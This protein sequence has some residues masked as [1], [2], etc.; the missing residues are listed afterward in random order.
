MVILRLILA[1]LAQASLYRTAVSHQTRAHASNHSTNLHAASPASAPL[2]QAAQR[3]QDPSP[4][5]K[6]AFPYT[7]PC[8][9]Y[10]IAL[11]LLGIIGNVFPAGTADTFPTIFGIPTILSLSPEIAFY[12]LKVCTR[13]KV[14]DCMPYGVFLFPES[15]VWIIQV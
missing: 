8:D 9:S 3:F 12:K 15:C 13:E 14:L 11:F 6:D 10:D 2:G 1:A 4:P 7:V 5:C